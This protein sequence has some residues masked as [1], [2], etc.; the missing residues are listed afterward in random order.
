MNGFKV[1]G[2]GLSGFRVQGEKNIFS[3]KLKVD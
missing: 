3:Q 1:Y 2:G